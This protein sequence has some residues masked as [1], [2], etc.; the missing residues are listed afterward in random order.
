M[1]KSK[2][3]QAE[4]LER[5]ERLDAI[6]NTAADA[7]ITIDAK[8][9]I[10]GANPATTAL[11]G[12]SEAE[13]VGRNVSIL[14]PS[15]IAD[16]H[17]GYLTH[18]RDTGEARIIGIGRDVTARR[19]DGTTFPI[20]LSVG[21]AKVGDRT[22][23]TGIVRDLTERAQEAA[24]RLRLGEILEESINEIFVFDEESLRF[25][26]VNR[27]A[28]E[29][30]GYSTDELAGLTPVDIKP[31]FEEAEFRTLIEPVRRGAIPSLVFKT[32]HRRK[33]GT[34]YRVEVHLQHHPASREYVAV[35]LDISERET[36]EE[37]LVQ[38][39]KMEA[40]GQLAGGIA[41]DFNNLLTSIQG[42]SDLLASR[43]D[44]E[45]RSMRA[46]RRI[47]QAAERGS[48]LTQQLLAFGRRQVSQPELLDVNSAVTQICD[49]TGRLIGEDVDLVL[50]LDSRP[51]SISADPTMFDQVL[52]NLVV[53]AGDAM[54][55]GGRLSITTSRVTV[56][57]EQAA[58][59]EMVPG[60]AVLLRL[61]DTG[62]GMS[63]EVLERAF[64]PFFTTKEVGKGT[65]L[66]LSTVHG[67][68]K[69][70][71]WGIEVDSEL[72]TGTRF[73]IWIPEASGT[74]ASSPADSS[75]PEEPRTRS[76]ILL[77]EDEW[78]VRDLALEILEEAGYHVLVARDP[79]EALEIAKERA[80]EIE[81]LISDVVM[82]G[83]SGLELARRLRGAAPQLR[84]LLMSGYPESALASRGALDPEFPMLKKPFSVETLRNRVRALLGV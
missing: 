49:L 15:D 10:E 32:V 59:L 57:A 60:P 73:L 56:D 66:G 76:K 9:L 21:E 44:P 79:E 36:L 52:M 3:L 31:E 2:L 14:M 69:Q 39:Q 61:Q 67:I 12:Y 74:R 7:I 16:E 19:K 41:H 68:I 40:V 33:D 29:N 5:V 83:M 18:Y 55:R 23:F 42:S 75:L 58:G 71:G 45:D 1:P 35:I 70:C 38:A 25:T 50:E 53:N 37:Q 72:G 26:Q 4:L 81:L 46:I 8:G 30:L 47:Q 11:F 65:G 48:S 43:L 20:H 13:L 28:R 27:G 77:V 64:E 22:L 62:A 54:P 17:D 51:L 6:L 24:Q 84:I 82:P 34:D 63:P 78:T 80:G